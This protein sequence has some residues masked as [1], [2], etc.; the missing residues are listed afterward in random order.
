MIGTDGIYRV[1]RYLPSPPDQPSDYEIYDAGPMSPAMI[2]A[3]L[4]TRPWSQAREDQFRGVDGRR[5][6][7]E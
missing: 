2:K 3:F 5:I 4:D 1:I 6:P 7:Q